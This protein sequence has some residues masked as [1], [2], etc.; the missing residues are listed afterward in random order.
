MN[1][2]AG[3]RIKQSGLAEIPIAHDPLFVL[4]FLRWVIDR[5]AYFPIFDFTPLTDTIRK[6]VDITV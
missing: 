5:K 2:Q 1:D 3:R 6:S 4:I